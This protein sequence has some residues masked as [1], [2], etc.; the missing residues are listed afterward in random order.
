MTQALQMSK[1]ASYR[2][3]GGVATTVWHRRAGKDTTA[4]N[5]TALASQVR[6]GTY[7]HLFPN[8]IQA[9]R[10][11][12]NGLTFENK[13]HL[14]AFPGFTRG[15][16]IV[17]RKREDDMMIEMANG[18]FYQLVGTENLDA[19]VGA[20]PVGLIVSEYALQDPRALALLEPII[21]ENG[22]WMWFTYTPRG[23]NHGH[24][25][26]MAELEDKE[27]FCDLL[28]I[29]D[30]RRPDGSPVMLQTQVDK[31]VN[32]G[33][34][35]QETADQEFHCS[36]NAGLEGSYYK[37]QIAKCKDEGRWKSKA[38]PFWEPNLPV[39]TFW[40]I[41]RRDYTTIVFCQQI[42]PNEIR[43]IDSYYSSGEDIRHYVQLIKSKPYTY[44]EHY[45]PHDINVTEWTANNESRRQIALSLGI[46]FQVMRKVADVQERIDATRRKLPLCVFNGQCKE[47]TGRKGLLDAVENYQKDWNPDRQ[48]FSDQPAKGWA[49]HYAD[50]FGGIA[51]TYKTGSVSRG[52]HS[53]QNFADDTYNIFGGNSNRQQYADENDYHGRNSW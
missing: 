45:A 51:L 26:Y 10:A 37:G 29:N 43:I 11:M 12:W 40:D 41:G 19:L 16:G 20:N 34:I 22:G 17:K 46:R 39:D 25:H 1:R 24:D 21:M 8:L 47:I 38:N 36:W 52:T 42:S 53:K 14:E 44:G 23:R 30:T 31:L 2:V 49:N 18:S 13:R 32:A 28:T 33:R 4:L 15:G 5:F 35:T 6:V 48:T 9:R 3:P 7:W 50:A 27:H